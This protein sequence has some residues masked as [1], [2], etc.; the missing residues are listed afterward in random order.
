MEMTAPASRDSSGTTCTA[1]LSSTAQVSV[2][3]KVWPIRTAP[4]LVRHQQRIGST[5]TI[6]S[7]FG[8]GWLQAAAGQASPTIIINRSLFMT[9]P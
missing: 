5:D 1:S 6:C 8:A 4:S 3:S 7:V 9:N 2:R